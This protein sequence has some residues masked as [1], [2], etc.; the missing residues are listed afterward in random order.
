MSNESTQKFLG[1]CR[2]LALEPDGGEVYEAGRSLAEEQKRLRDA[3]A[4][5]L[6][7]DKDDVKQFDMSKPLR[8]MPFEGCLP[9]LSLE[10]ELK[11]WQIISETAGAALDKYPTTIE[12]DR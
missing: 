6:G 2:F 4:E 7:V 5:E 9:K 10:N 12:H 3:K 11:A 1:F 8:K